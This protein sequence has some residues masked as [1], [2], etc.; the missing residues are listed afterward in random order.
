MHSRLSKGWFP[1]ST[2][3]TIALP[4]RCDSYRQSW[5]ISLDILTRLA[6]IWS[7]H[8]G[9]D[10]TISKVRGTWRKFWKRTMMSCC[11]LPNPVLWTWRDNVLE[12]HI[13]ACYILLNSISKRYCK[14]SRCLPLRLN[15]LEIYQNHFLNPWKLRRARRTVWLASVEFPP[16]SL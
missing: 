3:N 10:T 14:I 16:K 9:G 13:T 11:D 5:A 2:K 6:L 7:P 12:Q 15:T 4:K 1:I 8:Q